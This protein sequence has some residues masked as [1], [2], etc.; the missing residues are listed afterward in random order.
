MKLVRYSKNPILKPN[1]KNPWENF[2]TTNP[3]AWYEEETGRVLMLY[4]A[5][6]DDEAHVIRFGLAVS[7]NGYD[8]QR[9]SDQ[10]VF[11][12]STDGF[13]AGCVE[14][15]R[16]IKIGE[17]YYI[18]YAA[19]FYP[20]GRY[21]LV[22]GKPQVWK[23]SPPEFPYLIRENATVTG[24]ALTKD[25]KTWIRA[26]RITNPLVDDRDVI[27]FPEKIN[28]K[29]VM[30]HRPMSWVGPQYGTEHPAMWIS[31]SEDLLHWPKSTLLAAAKEDWECKIGG[32]TPPIR[33]PHGWLTLY[34][35][36]GP[37]RYYRLGAML[38]DLNNPARVTHRTKDW[39]FQPEEWYET[40]G[41][42]DG[43]GV[44]FPCGK[45][46]IKDTLFV[47]YGA[48]DK[49]VGLATCKL[50]ELLK[51]LLSCPTNQ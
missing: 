35:A 17:Y 16:I 5:A 25:F 21:W 47:Y 11:G 4:R 9:V 45:V 32:N 10:P 37:D 18:T 23:Q 8:F 43:G 1:P 31:F 41:C 48:A 46:V 12:P 30:L 50:N 19:R 28:G 26:G 51:Y 13:D 6:G 29:F 27:L 42:Y 14:D 2:V 20:P 33:T 24:L 39:I 15:P 44:V 7:S 3:G 40:Q 38:L 22:A 49:Y 36:V 34:H